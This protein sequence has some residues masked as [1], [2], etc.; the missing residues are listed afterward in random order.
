MSEAEQETPGGGEAEQTEQTPTDAAIEQEAAEEEDGE[1]TDAGH[2]STATD[3]P[4]G[5]EIDP[6]TDQ[7]PEPVHES[8]RFGE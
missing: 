7:G 8:E 5:A 1:Q 6:L 4:A 3:L 2:V